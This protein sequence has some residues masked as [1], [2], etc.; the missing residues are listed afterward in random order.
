MSEPAANAVPP[1]T[2]QNLAG[3]KT[4][5]RYTGIPPSWLDKRPK[6]PSRN[7]L[8]FIGVTSTI[9]GYYIYDR[10]KC[11][12]IRQEYVDRVKCLAEVPLHSLD[13]PRKVTVY[14]SKWPGDEDHG[15]SIKYFRKYVKPILVAAAVDYEII[16]GKRHGEL[17][18]RIADDIKRR[19]RIEA[20]LDQP[21][22][23]PMVLP[24]TSPE[25]KRRRELDGGVVIVGRP[26]FKEYMAGLKKGWTEGLELVDR[27]EALSRRLESDGRFDEPEPEPDLASASEGD[28]DDEP[29]PTAS[30]LPPSKPFT[31]FMPPHLQKSAPPQP[32][33]SHQGPTIPP[34]LNAPPAS[35]PQQPPILF[36]HFVNYIGLTQ[37]P[38]M[39]WEF[40]N[41]RYK[42]RA[43]AE[44]AYRLISGT[45]R[46][47]IGP[48]ADAL[49]EEADG[50][51]PAKP[52]LSEVTPDDLEFDKD[53][54]SYYKKSIVRSFA[55]E[56]EKARTEYYAG[57]PAKLETA[58]ALARGT[59]E[60]TKDEQSFPPPTEVELR[61]ERMKKE[62][63]WQ[64]D[65]V[66]WDIIKPERNV[67]WDER[68]RNAMSTFADPPSDKA[69]VVRDDRTS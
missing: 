45:T 60:P 67:A 35:I 64:A 66:G 54:E 28:T 25:D 46:P 59:R 15:R 34:H 48:V 42:V 65:E 1:P 51:S 47:F 5:L 3:V 8:I 17:M 16:S 52:H 14:G 29:I 4:V 24:N 44:A 26:T 6:L 58:R 53:T 38:H 30:R 43:G 63:R 37:I 50:T 31:A 22:L 2:K 11:K 12:E 21:P 55:S 32:S 49:H 33:Q 56:I 41:E 23:T 57:L 27:E 7:W 68:F 36:V 13:Y 61:A 19:R 39:I 69:D 18:N 20:G 10:R 9:A 62:L 40:F